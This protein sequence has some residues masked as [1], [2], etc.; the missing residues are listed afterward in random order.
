MELLQ[1]YKNSIIHITIAKHSESSIFVREMERLWETFQSTWLF[2][3]FFSPFALVSFSVKPRSYTL[4]FRAATKCMLKPPY[5]E[6][7]WAKAKIRSCFLHEAEYLIFCS[8]ILG[9]FLLEIAGRDLK[10]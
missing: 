4:L 3:L 8:S 7:E 6:G 1:T 10:P 5:T 9:A 2:I